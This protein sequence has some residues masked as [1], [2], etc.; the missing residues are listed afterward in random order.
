[1][2]SLESIMDYWNRQGYEPE[3]SKAGLMDINTIVNYTHDIEAYIGHGVILH[4]KNHADWKFG[5][6]DHFRNGMIYI[7]CG[8]VTHLISVNDWEYKIILPMNFKTMNEEFT[9]K[10]K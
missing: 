10:E 1:M 9:R 3:I 7:K 4:S 8:I 2:K 5:I 6:I